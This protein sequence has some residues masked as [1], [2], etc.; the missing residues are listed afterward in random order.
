MSAD[1]RLDLS[2]PVPP[3][4]QI[5]AGIAGLVR[6]GVLLPG[7]RLPTVRSLA[8]DLGVAAGT[9]A[10]A[11]RE[12]EAAG[13]VE[14]HGRRGTTVRPA[15]PRGPAR[16]DLTAA[17]ALAAARARA[18]GVPVDELVTLVRR[19]YLDDVQASGPASPPAPPP[20][21]TPSPTPSRTAA[22]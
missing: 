3:F 8:A 17:V 11:Y 7:A 12:L 4:E 5:R 22:N 20:T 9:V 21:S 1:L 18:D 13:V 19:A 16:P 15:P 14:G 10:R 6:S 2:S